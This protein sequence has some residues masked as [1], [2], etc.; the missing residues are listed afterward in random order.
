M[1]FPLSFPYRY[2]IIILLY[3][4]TLI[5][6]L[7]RVTISLVGVRIKAALHLSNTEFGWV[8][9][10]FALAYALCE[11][12]SAILGDRIGQRK[13][14]I[15]IVLWWSLFTAL[16]G[17]VSGLATLIMVRFFFGVGESGVYPNSSG[18]ISRWFPKYE[19]TRGISWLM[20]GGNSGAGIAPLIVVPIAVA[21]GWRA[22]F[23]VN[24]FIGLI[25]VWVC[26]RWFRNHP[27]EMKGISAEE[28]EFI[29]ANRRFIRHDQPFPWKKATRSPMVWA[30]VI[31]FFCTQWA[32]YFFIAWM[33]NYLQE[34]KHF[35]E[36]EMKM[37]T[38]YLFAFGIFAALLCGIV[39]DQLIKKIGL[40]ISRRLVA[41]TCFTL[42]TILILISAEAVNHQVVAI[43]LISA[44]FF[45]GAAVVTCFSTCVDIGGDRAATIAGIMNFVGQSGAF[46]M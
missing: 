19:T 8:L 12:P 44:H 40:R 28:K 39:S 7:D 16:T 15:R 43:T 33:P 21:F 20:M 11:I 17:V 31:S 25:W 35:S 29:E 4:L 45:V 14:F 30:L 13:V 1:G 6:Y 41:M 38:S 34:G 26:Y 36:Q 23:F 32:N 27:S 2:R 46:A 3:F 42:M 37:A 18:T 24:A 5:T 9:G 10:A 22:P